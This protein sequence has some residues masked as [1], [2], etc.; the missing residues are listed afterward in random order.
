VWLKENKGVDSPKWEKPGS[1]DDVQFLVTQNSVKQLDLRI[2][3][4]NEI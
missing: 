3:T 4:P 1:S 2:I